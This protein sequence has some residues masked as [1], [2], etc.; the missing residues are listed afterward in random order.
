MQGESFIKE[1]GP[2]FT[3][4]TELTNHLYSFKKGMRAMDF[5]LLE[6][7]LYLILHKTLQ[8]KCCW[9]TDNKL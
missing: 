1:A 3:T 8:K 6:Q 5:N 4:K 7:K 9:K 2:R